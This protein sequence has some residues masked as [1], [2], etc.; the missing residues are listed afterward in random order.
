MLTTNPD[1]EVSI[2]KKE[3]SGRIQTK[4]FL[5]MIIMMLVVMIVIIITL[6]FFSKSS[7]MT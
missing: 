7:S 3:K 1:E 2:E 4:Y 6:R 5:M